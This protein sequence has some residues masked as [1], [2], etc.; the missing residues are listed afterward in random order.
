[1]K[2][3]LLLGNSINHC[4]IEQILSVAEMSSLVCSTCNFAALTELQLRSHTFHVH[5]DYTSALVCPKCQHPCFSEAGLEKHK[6]LYCAHRPEFS[7]TSSSPPA[8]F[9]LY[10]K[11]CGKCLNNLERHPSWKNV[12]NGQS[13]CR[14]L[15]LCEECFKAN[16]MKSLLTNATI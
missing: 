13:Y 3:S 9:S 6:S 5:K 15:F 1:M 8:L 11:C 14:T 4:D 7:R 10:L 16:E 12:K 2:V